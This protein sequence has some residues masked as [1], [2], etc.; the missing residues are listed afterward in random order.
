VYNISSTDLFR[1]PGSLSI[2]NSGTE[3]FVLNSQITISTSYGEN[4]GPQ[5]PN[6]PVDQ[7]LMSGCYE[8]CPAAFDPDGDSLSYALMPCPVVSYTFPGSGSSPATVNN[9]GL[10]QFCNA[11]LQGQYNLVLLVKEW[12][13]DQCG[14][15]QLIGQVGRDL[16]MMILTG[17]ASP[18][19]LTAP[20]PTCIS[21]GTYTASVAGTYTGSLDVNLFG[22]PVEMQGASITPT[23][24]LGTVSRTVSWNA[25][26]QGAFHLP[27]DFY[28]VASMPGVQVNQRTYNHW[29]VKL[30]PPSPAMGITTIDTSKIV[31]NW[32]LVN[33]GNRG[34]SYKIYRKFGSDNWQSALCTGG[35]PSSSGYINIAT[36]S[37]TV[38][39]YTDYDLWNIPSGSQG[40]YIVTTLMDDCTESVANSQSVTLIVGLKEN[41][42]QNSVSIYPNPAA[43]KFTLNTGSDLR[44]FNVEIISANGQMIFQS[45]INGNK[46][47]DTSGWSEGI[48]LV[49][50]KSGVSQATFKFIRTPG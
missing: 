34:L 5:L 16:Q 41:S 38:S 22:W 50:V 29:T 43:D 46:E 27:H 32:S 39:T 2:G 3:P 35:V 33:C 28:M 7:G 14:A 45:I 17:N 8:H 11:S 44:L 30:N 26:C 18:A 10:I 9:F 21:G 24:G 37:G 48:Y 36:V 19:P 40:N 15:Y 1:S 20:T 6:P 13:R 4:T 47:I 31:L 49:R 25:N 12:R 23:L 42:L